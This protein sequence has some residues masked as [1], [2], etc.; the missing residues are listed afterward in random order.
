[1]GL[2]YE[3]T[4]TATPQAG[5]TITSIVPGGTICPTYCAAIPLGSLP[6]W[7]MTI[8][9][10]AGAPPDGT[11]T[12]NVTIND[13]M[14]GSFTT[15]TET[16]Y[17]SNQQPFCNGGSPI[18]GSTSIY[19]IEGVNGAVSGITTVSKNL[20]LPLVAGDSIKT[21]LYYSIPG[22]PFTAGISSMT[23]SQTSLTSAPVTP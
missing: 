13:S 4:G 12:F 20:T 16:I 10:S 7:Y 11:Y 2:N 8:A 1:M 22:S 9:T 21:D 14:G 18:P 6:N 17:V 23:A 5:A 19:C 15:P 3:A